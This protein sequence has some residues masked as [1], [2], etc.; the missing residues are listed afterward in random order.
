MDGLKICRT[1]KKKT[2]VSGPEERL[3]SHRDAAGGAA[4]QAGP[5]DEQHHRLH[6][7]QD[8]GGNYY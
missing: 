2:F 6:A 4:G 8:T 3:P 7:A 5:P 1:Q